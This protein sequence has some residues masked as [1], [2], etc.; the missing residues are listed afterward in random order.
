MPNLLTDPRLALEKKSAL[1]FGPGLMRH[2]PSKFGMSHFFNRSGLS[3][4]NELQPLC[5]FLPP[6]AGF[7]V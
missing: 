7:E 3:F 5:D 1:F 4:T 6:S 2:P